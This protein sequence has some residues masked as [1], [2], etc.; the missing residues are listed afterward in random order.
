MNTFAT[1]DSS[2]VPDGVKIME[3]C[4]SFKRKEDS[5]GNLKEKRCRINADGRQQD[6]DSCGDTFAPTSK[7][8]CFRTIYAIA[9]QE[10]LKLY[11]FDVKGA[12]PMAPCEEPI[13]LNPPG[14]CR[15]PKG[16]ALKCLRYIYGLRQ[17]AAHW[18]KLFAKWLKD[19]GFENINS[20]GVTWSMTGRKK[21][22]TPS[23]LLLTV[24]VDNVN[25]D[26][27]AA[28]NDP[29][30]YQVFLEALRKNFELSDCGELTWL[31]GCKVEQEKEQGMVRLHQEKY[32]ND[33]LKRFQ[34]AD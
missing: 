10:G 29:N 23:K 32:C 28:C 26:G 8:S 30:M 1:V 20:D 19:Y 5:D 9:A 6:K 27:L 4:F 15:L 34:M 16:K 24:H 33:V 25:D 14:R 17:S 31:L 11:Q 18:H 7:F 13:Y 22:G 12:F 3:T 2:S 21:D